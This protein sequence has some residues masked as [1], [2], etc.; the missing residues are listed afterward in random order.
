VTELSVK[1]H[2]AWWTVLVIDPI[3][4]PLVALVDRARAITPNTVTVAS[5]VIAALSALEW[6]RSEAIAAAVLFQ[7]AFLLDCMDGKLAYLRHLESPYGAWLDAASDA[8]RMTVCY[9]GFAWWMA[10]RSDLTRA[11]I[12]ALAAYPV[13]HA[14]VMLSG[15]AWPVHDDDEPRRAIP[16]TTIA[17]LRAAPG[18]LGLPGSTVDAEA[19]VFTVGP[20]LA[21][22]VACLWLATAFNL[23]HLVVALT[24]RTVRVATEGGSR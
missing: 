23:V 12:L 6:V 19:L 7:I 21:V 8:V 13:L 3:A 15:R 14:G 17:M 16:A 4:A 10:G 9:A 2:D 20:L 24:V 1:A 22:P 11:T 5:V 18:R